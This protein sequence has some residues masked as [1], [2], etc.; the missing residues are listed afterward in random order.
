[1]QGQDE[2]FS[3]AFALLRARQESAAGIIQVLGRLTAGEAKL[4]NT[5]TDQGSNDSACLLA[6]DL[7][8]GVA[9]FAKQSGAAFS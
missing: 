6:E 3:Q 4:R 7:S 5:D 2:P 1:M 8:K 9:P